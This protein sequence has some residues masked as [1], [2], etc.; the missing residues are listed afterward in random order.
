[1]YVKII[2]NGLLIFLLFAVQVAFIPIL[3][4]WLSNLNLAL[5]VLVYLLVSGKFVLTMSW[6]IALGFLFDTLS[7]VFFGLHLLSIILAVLA[8]NFL[9]KNFFTNRSLY[10][11]AVLTTFMTL[12]YN[13]LL[14]FG[15]FINGL[16]KQQGSIE[17]TKYYW[18]GITEQLF[19]NLIITVILFYFL[20][21]LSGRFKPVF[22]PRRHQEF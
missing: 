11:F 15:G 2:F 22:L 8:T 16:L 10:S 19:L 1:M 20:N 13:A 14:L 17:L 3:P 18:A 4:G 9:L 7:F 6:A 5:V 12:A 21:Y